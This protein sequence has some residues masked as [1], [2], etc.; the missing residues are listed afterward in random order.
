MRRKHPMIRKLLLDA[1]AAGLALMVF[2]LF[3][4]VLPRAQQSLNVQTI[5]PVQAEETAVPETEEVRTAEAKAEDR[6]AAAEP[7][8]DETASATA[9]EKTEG[10]R[11]TILTTASSGR[12]DSGGRKSSSRQNSRKSGKSSGMNSKGGSALT[13][14]DEAAEASAEPAD[15][16]PLAEKFADRFTNSVTVTENSYTSPDISITVNEVNEENLTYYVADIYVRDITCFQT[17]L[18]ENTYGS[19]F[20]DSIEDMAVL[21]NALLA[22]NGDYYGNTTEGVVIRNGVIYRANPTDCD[23]CVLY[24]DGSM[25]VM[26]GSSFSVEEA[27]EDGAWQAWTFGPALLDANGNPITAF[28]ST[29]RITNAN[30]RTAIGY[31][32]PGHYCLVVVD[33]RGESSGISLPRLSRLFDTLGCIAAYNLDGGNSSIMVWGNEVINNPSGGG[34]ESSDALLIAEVRNDG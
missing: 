11:P 22:V 10:Y 2:A 8:T 9:A 14:N 1:A 4:H 19:G 12:S 31:Y 27:V 6:T 18:A 16:T 7:E 23:V 28:A 24:Y 25:K 20:R 21:N 5:R 33:G 26:P 29:S 17:A 30:P 34:R 3:H 32:E 15:E 13:E